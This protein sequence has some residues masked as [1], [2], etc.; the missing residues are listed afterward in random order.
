MKVFENVKLTEKEKLDFTYVLTLLNTS[1]EFCVRPIP[2]DEPIE[3]VKAYYDG[4]FEH[5]KEAKVQEHIMRCQLS[6]KYG[7]PYEF[8]YEDGLVGIEDSAE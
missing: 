6:Q 5:M 4:I 3:S 1:M 8:S 7:I 2:V